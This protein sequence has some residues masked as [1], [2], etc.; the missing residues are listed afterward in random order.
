[1]NL[2]LN[3]HLC[4]QRLRAHVFGDLD[5]AMAVF[6]RDVEA[7]AAQGES[8]NDALKSARAKSARGVASSGIGAVAF[9]MFCAIDSR[10]IAPRWPIASIA[11]FALALAGALVFAWRYYAVIGPQGWQPAWYRLT[12]D[13]RIEDFPAE[14]AIKPLSRM[15]SRWK[16]IVRLAGFAGT[17][18]LLAGMAAIRF[19][20]MEWRN[21]GYWATITV[22]V[23]AV[24]WPSIYLDAIDKAYHHM[25]AARWFGD[26]CQSSRHT[27]PPLASSAAGECCEQRRTVPHAARRLERH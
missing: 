3:L 12:G 26:A 22:V 8:K 7:A 15:L 23:A 17:V 19:A 11:W 10:W 20:P 4:A 16:F 25:C 6:R 14:R 13:P 27:T 21:P 24:Y 5:A 9:L 1:M 2:N 18:L